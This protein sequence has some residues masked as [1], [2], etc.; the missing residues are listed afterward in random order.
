MRSRAEVLQRLRV[1]GMKRKLAGSVLNG[2]FWMLIMLKDMKG[3]QIFFCSI[4]ITE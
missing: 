4:K 3:H 1:R 2:L